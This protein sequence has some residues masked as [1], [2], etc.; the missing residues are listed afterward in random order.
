MPAPAGLSTATNSDPLQARLR[1]NNF[2]TQTRTQVLARTTFSKPTLLDDVFWDN[3]AG[4]FTDGTVTGIGVLPNGTDGGVEN[5]DLGMTDTPLGNLS[6]RGSVIQTT[7]G[8]DVTVAAPNTNTITDTASVKDPFDLTVDVLASRTYP[9]FRQSTIV[10]QVLPPNLLGDYHLTGS[11]SPA[12][13]AGL[14]SLLVVWGTSTNAS[15][16]LQ[17]PVQAPGDD[18]EGDPRPSSGSRYDA[19]ADQVAGGA[20]AATPLGTSPRAGT[21]IRPPRTQEQQR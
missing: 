3:R 13:G 16:R 19:G 20:P 9:A 10:A 12:F 4:T 1:N 2:F 18:R 17:Y 14:A 8:T 5:W 21:R 15:Q 6:P 7:R 11:G